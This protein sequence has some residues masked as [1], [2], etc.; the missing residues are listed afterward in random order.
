MNYYVAHRRK[1]KQVSMIY[2]ILEWEIN[3]Y[4]ALTN[5][6]LGVTIHI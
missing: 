2:V 5:K 6:I 3:F 1:L 4:V